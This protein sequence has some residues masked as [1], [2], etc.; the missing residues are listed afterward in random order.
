MGR[1]L[2]DARSPAVEGAIEGRLRLVAD[3]R[4]HLGLC[5]QRFVTVFAVARIVLARRFGTGI[6]SL[7]QSATFQ[8]VIGGFVVV[9]IVG[10]AVS[11]IAV[12]RH[13][14]DAAAR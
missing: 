8:W 9:A 12:W 2:G 11:L 13:T 14:E 10:T 7:L 4:G 1:L 3:S 5:R 6:L